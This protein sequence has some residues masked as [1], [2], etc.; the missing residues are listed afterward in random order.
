MDKELESYDLEDTDILELFCLQSNLQPNPGCNGPSLASVKDASSDPPILLELFK[1]RWTHVFGVYETQ[2]DENNS[3]LVNNALMYLKDDPVSRWRQLLARSKQ[4]STPSWSCCA[5]PDGNKATQ[6]DTESESI[7]HE[8]DENA[9]VIYLPIIHCHDQ[10][11]S[12]PAA[13]IRHDR[14]SGRRS[15]TCPHCKSTPFETIRSFVTHARQCTETKPSARAKTYQIPQG[16]CIYLCDY[17]ATNYTTHE[18]LP[19][20]WCSC[21]M[22]TTRGAKLHKCCPRK[23]KPLEQSAIEPV[24][25]F[26]YPPEKP[27][28]ANDICDAVFSSL[29]PS[30]VRQLGLLDDS[31]LA[32]TVR[33]ALDK[34]QGAAFPSF[35]TCIQ[36]AEFKPSLPNYSAEHT[37]D[38]DAEGDSAATLLESSDESNYQIQ[39]SHNRTVEPLSNHANN[40]AFEKVHRSSMPIDGPTSDNIHLSMGRGPRTIVH[41]RNPELNQLVKTSKKRKR[42]D[43]QGMPYHVPGRE[44][45]ETNDLNTS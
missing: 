11:P 42:H 16:S 12:A 19:H 25:Y 14:V 20:Y 28:T 8:K 1:A 33:K 44:N 37:T 7:S 39:P 2:G 40:G 10:E 34:Y 13:S 9:D 24:K 45:K 17:T 35:G 41:F 31:T 21:G 5:K 43:A 36:V 32:W 6:R 26:A 3:R 18:N 23:K 38:Y 15:Y 30:S 27:P 22:I 4:K 29:P